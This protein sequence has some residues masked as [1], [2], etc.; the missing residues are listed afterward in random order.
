VGR[1]K[2]ECDGQDVKDKKNKVTIKNDFHLLLEV[3]SVFEV[4]EFKVS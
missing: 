3:V 2:N 4:L 1:L